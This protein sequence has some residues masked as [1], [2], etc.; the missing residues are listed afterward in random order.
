MTALLAD[1][2]LQVRVFILQVA[3]FA[4]K[5]RVFILQVANYRQ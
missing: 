4:G 3:N 2:S 5:V 1:Y